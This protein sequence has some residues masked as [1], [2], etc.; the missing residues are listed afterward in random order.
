[1][2]PDNIIL[3]AITGST[4]YGLNTENS[5]I[6][7]MGIFVAPTEKILS[8]SNIKETYVHN[9][10]DWAY[11]EVGKFIHL[12]MKGNPTILE[13]LFADGYLT[14]TKMGKMLVDNRHHFLSNVIFKS[15]GGYAYSQV[16]KLNA[17][18]GTYGSGR[19]NRYEKHSRHLL[20]LLQQGEQLITTGTLDVKVDNRD[21]LFEFGHKTPH[22]IVTVFE[23]RIQ[24]FNKLES[25]LPD[26]PNIDELNRML[27]KIRKA[28]WS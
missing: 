14:L 27:I 26:K 28:N 19:S 6:D 4:A 5:D 8:L 15:Y 7:Q 25:I 9:D 18:G 12:A 17:R 13:L 1:M 22:E 11:H 20:R 2:K 21:E 23:E 24:R 3:E 10:P 16:R